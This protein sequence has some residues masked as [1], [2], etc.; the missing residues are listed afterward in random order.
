M[1]YYDSEVIKQHISYHE[2]SKEYVGIDQIWKN[3]QYFMDR[4]NALNIIN[5]SYVT[6]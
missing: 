3:I 6:L 4:S 2:C 1:I 5:K